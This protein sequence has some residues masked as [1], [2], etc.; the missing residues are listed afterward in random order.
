MTQELKNNLQ[1]AIFEP[2]EKYRDF[3]HDTLKI[4]NNNLFVADSRIQLIDAAVSM[5]PGLVILGEEYSGT[6]SL[7]ALIR[8]RQE[9]K[10]PVMFAD[11]S[12]S[13]VHISNVLESGADQYWIKGRRTGTE[14]L[15]FSRALLRRSRLGDINTPRDIIN[16]GLI[17]TQNGRITADGRDIPLSP[18]EFRVL[19]TLG[20]NM[21]SIVTHAEFNHT[22]YG[23]YDDD[24]NGAIS[25]YISRIR[26]KFRE[27][28]FKAPIITKQ[29]VGYFMPYYSKDQQNER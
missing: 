23:D 27:A 14:F 19:R 16:G 26:A 6:A 7:D 21:G 15:A 13:D 10:V 22:L 20:S 18:Q 24:A 3:F 25:I 4:A 11:Y 5:N 29:R 2:D 1:I 17:I 9:S 28:K 12:E 8:L